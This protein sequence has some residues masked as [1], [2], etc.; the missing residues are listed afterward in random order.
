MRVLAIDTTTPRGSLALVEGDRVCG[1]VRVTGE[2]AHSARLLPAVEFLLDSLQLSASDLEAYAVA[3]GPGSFTGIRIG[4]STVQGLA[5]GSGRPCLGISA[6][7]VLAAR[8]RGA[9][10]C[11]VVM[12]D[13]FRGEVYAGLYDRAAAPRGPSLVA[14]PEALLEQV[15]EEAAFVGEGANRYRSLVLARRPRAVFPE[16]SLFLAGTLG[17]LAAPRL[18]AREGI[19]PQDL[20]PVYLREP[21]IRKP[22][23]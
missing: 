11:L 2:A 6:L 16:R 14:K 17:L 12:M 19:G 15:P 20:R 22:T 3:T 5:L 13:A 7:D 1:E 9:A 23:R 4:I 8:I 18:A 10:P 21:D